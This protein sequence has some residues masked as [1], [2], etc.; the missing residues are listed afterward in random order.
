MF[1][2]LPSMIILVTYVF[3][4]F[5]IGAIELTPSNTKE[6]FIL[7][8]VSVYHLIWCFIMN[9]K[10]LYIFL[11][12]CF[13]TNAEQIKN[14]IASQLTQA[15]G[16]VS[17]DNEEIINIREVYGDTISY[18]IP[19]EFANPQMSFTWEGHSNYV[20]KVNLGAIIIEAFEEWNRGQV[21]IQRSLDEI[22]RGISIRVNPHSDD[23][24]A[25]TNFN[26]S[27]G[28]SFL[29]VN[30]HTLERLLLKNFDAYKKRNIIR[31]EMETDTYIR[32]QLKIIFKHEFGHAL[33][34][35]HNIDD[36]VFVGGVEGRLLA[37]SSGYN[38]WTGPSI[39]LDGSTSDYMV[40]LNNYTGQPVSFEQIRPNANDYEAVRIMYTQTGVPPRVGTCYFCAIGL[41]TMMR[42]EF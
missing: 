28:H 42:S 3:V 16:S 37:Q 29:N 5:M 41:A 23:S 6:N 38:F 34:L 2:T 11:I 39:M 35:Q 10:W 40:E 24:L 12:V 31:Q 14:K 13:S 7:H 17:P 8:S 30:L 1:E 20:M 4:L 26:H 22:E 36:N 18:Y 27:T 33:G 21:R 15:V 25:S 32:L 19:Q 9:G